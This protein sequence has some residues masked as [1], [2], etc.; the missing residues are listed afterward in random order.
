MSLKVSPRDDGCTLVPQW[1]LVVS[2]QWREYD[3]RSSR[4]TFS[5]SSSPQIWRSCSKL[6]SQAAS[7]SS[8]RSA[9][10]GGGCR[11][12]SSL[13]MVTPS[14]RDGVT[15]GL[16]P[17]AGRRVPRAKLRAALAAAPD[18][19]P[20]LGERPR[21]LLGVL[22]LEDA[23]DLRPLHGPELRFGAALG[24]ADEPLRRGQGQ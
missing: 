12:S 24:A 9:A 7:P 18:R 4:S 19:R 16:R 22:R 21:P 14:L 3:P 11:F 15:L 6:A 2:V 10:G 1:L 13:S 20:L 5:A 17:T 23:R 8:S